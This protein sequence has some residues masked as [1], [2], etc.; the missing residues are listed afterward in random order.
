MKTL[1]IALLMLLAAC[2]PRLKDGQIV[3]TGFR[4]HQTILIFMPIT[5]CG[6]SCTVSLIPL[7]FFYPDRW[8]VKIKKYDGKEW[9][10]ATWWV[11]REVFEQAKIGGYFKADGRCL[12]CEPRKRTEKQ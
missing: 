12:D 1:L 6:K 4:A 5:T 8:Y 7:F 9:H 11:P 10:A 2:T 3:E